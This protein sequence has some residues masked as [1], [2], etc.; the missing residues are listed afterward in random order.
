MKINGSLKPAFDTIV[1]FGENSAI[2]HAKPSSRKLKVGDVILIDF[3]ATFN[4]YCSDMTR[5]FVFG[6]CS[7]EIEKLYNI[8]LGANEIAIDCIRSGIPPREADR[9]ARNYLDLHRME[10]YFNHSLGHGVGLEIHEYP[11][12]SSRILT[13]DRLEDR[14]SVV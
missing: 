6:K 7:E 13:D 5:T 4:G 12:L 8:V 2:A 14:K 10:S 3:G 9:V 1:A 11:A